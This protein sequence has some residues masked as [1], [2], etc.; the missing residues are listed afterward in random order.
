MEIEELIGK[1]VVGFKFKGTPGYNEDLM[2]QLEGVLGKVVNYIKSNSICLVSF[3]DTVKGA[4]FY[5][6]Y[7]EILKHVKTDEQH[8]DDLFKE[9]N[10]LMKKIK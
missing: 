7:P 1:K 2:P 3:N 8:A 6:P 5:Y 9:I 4:E 10:K